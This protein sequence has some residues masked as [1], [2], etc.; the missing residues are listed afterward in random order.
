N[1]GRGS[2]FTWEGGHTLDAAIMDGSG[3]A[4]GAV[5]ASTTTRHPVA[6]ARAV[7]EKSRHVLLA[8]AGADA[9]ARDQG[10]EQ[11]DNVWFGTEERRQQLDW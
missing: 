3:R 11:V 6:L 4:A 9:F 5:A 7:M 2:V 10:L 8:G 1:A